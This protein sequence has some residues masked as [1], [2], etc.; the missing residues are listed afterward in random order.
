MFLLISWS[1]TD[2]SAHSLGN[3]LGGKS[4]PNNSLFRTCHGTNDSPTNVP[5]A[6]RPIYD[7]HP[8]M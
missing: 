3:S 1:E 6:R 7:P 8:W 5:H 4:F 2:G